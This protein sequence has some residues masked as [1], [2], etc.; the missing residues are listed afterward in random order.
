MQHY[1]PESGVY[2]TLWLIFLIVSAA[3]I[4]LWAVLG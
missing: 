3:C 4:F 1:E 2:I